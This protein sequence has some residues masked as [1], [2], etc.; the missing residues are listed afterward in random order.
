MTDKELTPE[1]I[2]AERIANEEAKLRY[3]QEKEAARLKK[4]N[5]ARLKAKVVGTED[6]VAMFNEAGIQTTNHRKYIDELIEQEDETA[7]D[8]ILDK[9]QA[10]ETKFAEEMNQREVEKLLSKIDLSLLPQDKKNNPK[11]KKYLDKQTALL[12]KLDELLGG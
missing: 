9:K 4:E 10:V 1:E 2:E 3:E 12:A 11:V 5:I 6:L 8:A 7:L